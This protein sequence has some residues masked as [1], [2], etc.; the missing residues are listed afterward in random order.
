[1]KLL[2]PDLFTLIN[3]ENFSKRRQNFEYFNTG[4]TNQ[5]SQEPVA[6]DKR[7]FYV[8]L[9][10]SGNL[11]VLSS[12]I[13]N[14][15]KEAKFLLQ[16]PTIRCV[17]ADQ[18]FPLTPPIETE[19]EANPETNNLGLGKT[20]TEAIDKLNQPKETDAAISLDNYFIEDSINLN[21]KRKTSTE[22]PRLS[23]LSIFNDETKSTGEVLP[24][25]VKAVWGGIDISKQGN[26]GKGSYVFVIDSGVSSSTDD[27]NLNEEWSKS[28][29]PNE[30]AFTDGDGH[31][32]HVAGTIAALANGKG[33]IGVA[34]GA[35]VISLKVFDSNGSGASYS[36]IMDAVNYATTIIND[37]NLDKSKVVINMSLGG[38]YSEGMDIAIKNAADQGIKFAVAAGNSGSDADGYSP[39]SAGDHRNIYTVSAVDNNYQMPSWSN[40]DDQA[41]GDDV[42]VAAPGVGVYSYY[43]N[44]QLTYLSGTSMAAPH[45]AGALLIGGVKNGAMVAPNQSGYSD[46]FAL[47][48]SSG[49]INSDQ[50]I[51]VES[52]GNTSLLKANGFGFAQSGTN[53]P[54]AIRS[55]NGTAWGDA[56]WSGWTAVGAESI[57]GIN[58]TAWES[59]EGQLWFGQHDANWFFTGEGGYAD[60]TSFAYFQAESNFNQDFNEDEVTGFSFAP[61]ES[62]GGTSLLKA[63]G[64]GFAQSGNSSP[65]AITSADGTPLGDNTWSGWTVIGAESINGINTSAWESNSGQLWFAQHDAN[66]MY[67]SSGGY[68]DQNSLEYFQA[69]SNFNQNFNQDNIIGIAY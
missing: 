8:S 18:P 55:S 22:L 7:L 60:P 11:P 26:L 19:T 45:V 46:P 39:A 37:N 65:L 15:L 13:R 47:A 9:E 17:E 24:Y 14:V 44:G 56:T 50:L 54:Q 12:R 6:N 29:V 31:G 52:A 57:D 10:G 61:T 63:N 4:E 41:G 48:K 23:S 25:G 2:T 67:V 43:K 53:A 58:T 5:L 36:I 30:N 34:A 28:W 16:D 20:Y 38:G 62:A 3:S 1:M 64:F 51:D 40:W 66:W 68:A 33:V 59:I 21:P 35:E 42:D 69:E 49:S 32:T 27:L